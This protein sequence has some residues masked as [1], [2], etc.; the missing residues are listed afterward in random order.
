M[1]NQNKLITLYKFIVHIIITE[2][3]VEINL[4]INLPITV[5]VNLETKTTFSYLTEVILII[6]P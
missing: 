6:L 5:R 3:N 2:K 4:Y 1:K